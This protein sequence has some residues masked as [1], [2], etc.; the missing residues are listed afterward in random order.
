MGTESM[1]LQSGK[2][3]Y[4]NQSGEVIS[5]EYLDPLVATADQMEQ[6]AG[7]MMDWLKQAVGINQRVE[8]IK[9]PV[10]SILCDKRDF[11]AFGY[12]NELRRTNVRRQKRWSTE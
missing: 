8:K 6:A 4:L 11:G 3:V 5:E 1:L 12:N 2:T 7:K 9:L 10:T